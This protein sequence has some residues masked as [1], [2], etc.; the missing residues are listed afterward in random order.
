MVDDFS[1]SESFM[2]RYSDFDK[3]RVRKRVDREFMS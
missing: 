3:E 2:S 1:R